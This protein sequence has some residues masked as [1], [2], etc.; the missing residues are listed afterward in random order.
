MA[1]N[2]WDRVTSNRVARRRVL[3]SGAALSAGAAALALVGCGNDDEAGTVEEEVALPPGSSV[4][5]LGQF[6]PSDGPPQP[7]GRFT[8]S[9]TT[10]QNYNPVGNWNEGNGLG[11]TH[12][13]DRPL[14]SREDERRFVLEAMQS[15][16]TPDP[17]TVIMKLKPNQFFQDVAPV[18][19]RA[20][21]AQDVVASQD[22]GRHASANFDRTFIDDFLE[23]AEAP[24]DLTVIY[25]L[26]KPNAYLFSQNMLG[27]GT[28]QPITPFETFANI[29]SATQVGSGPYQIKE[30]TL[31]VDYTYE[32]YPRFREASN[33]L[34]YI[35]ERRIVFIPDLQA[36][37]A[38]FRGGR[39]D[40]W[41]GSATAEKTVQ[42]DMGD[43]ILRVELLSFDPFFLHMNMYR[44]FPWETD[45]RVRQAFM[46]LTNR[47]QILE[48]GFNDSGVLPIGL[49]P[50]SLRRYQLDPS[51]P[52]VQDFYTEDVAEAKKLLAAAD[53]PRDKTWDCMA[54]TA[55]SETD[56]SA[57]IW[58]QQLLRADVKTKISNVQGAAQLFQ[59]WSD[60]DWEIMHQGSLGT[61]TPGQA[62]RN[63]H[64]K[65][66]S[67]T[68]WR[69]GAR[70]PEVD[71]LIEESEAALD[72]EEN[73]ALVTAAQLRAMEIFTPSPMLLTNFSNQFLQKRIQAYE[74]T[75]VSPVYQLPMWIKDD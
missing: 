30:Q 37:E 50:A 61:D 36:R 35:A 4:S 64:S 58:Q 34:P 52:T 28:G 68:Y 17:L 38:A 67:D 57:Q 44:G 9:W 75:Q 40:R 2:F 56:A 24:D 19:G 71:R 74:V 31:S 27:S 1:G 14:T 59:R 12:V 16:E 11:G 62:L 29:D 47:K 10:S 66:W 18:N 51:H 3:R 55:G 20:L 70:D 8:D 41:S 23:T 72:F 13:Y 54:A 7:G 25:N 15:I 33:G 69:F 21:V 43:R 22:F 46:R 63:Q 26:K 39:T 5:S 49:L 60:N 32:K 65:G 42:Q 45:K 73:L 6:T 48:L 53:F